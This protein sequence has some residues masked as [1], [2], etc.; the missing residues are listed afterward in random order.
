VFPRES[1]HNAAA[2][3]STQTK[4][5]AARMGIFSLGRQ[6]K[7]EISPD[8]AKISIAPIPVSPLHRTIHWRH[9][10]IRCAWSSPNWWNFLRRCIGRSARSS[11]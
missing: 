1:H 6:T 10:R 9:L 2:G 4:A 5:C 7:C 8:P 11:D 3:V